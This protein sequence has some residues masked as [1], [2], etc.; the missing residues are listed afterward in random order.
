MSIQDF[1]YLHM[2]MWNEDLQFK[3]DDGDYFFDS[4]ELEGLCDEL[5]QKLHEGRAEL[6]RRQEEGEE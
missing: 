4:D 6:V 1:Q 2:G 3:D 5:E